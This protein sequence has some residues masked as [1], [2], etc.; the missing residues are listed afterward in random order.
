MKNYISLF[1]TFSI[2][3]FSC[4]SNQAKNAVSKTENTTT[5]I[6]DGTSKTEVKLAI[7]G[8]MCAHACGGKIQQDL[9]ATAGVKSTSLDFIDGRE[10]NVV[11]VEIDSN[12]I[13]PE[14]L[15]EVVHA[16]ADGKYHVVSMQTIVH[17]AS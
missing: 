8:M 6:V 5:E 7:T 15:S 11:T 1:I 10:Q 16:I 12:T 2:L 13:Q 3:L 9:Q 4:S 14:K 17:K